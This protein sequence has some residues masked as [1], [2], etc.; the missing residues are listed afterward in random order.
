[1]QVKS[2]KAVWLVRMSEYDRWLDAQEI[3]SSAYNVKNVATA[4][5]LILR[6]FE[7]NMD[8]L[9]EAWED[10]PDGKRWVPIESVIGRSKIPAESA[11]IVRKAID[12]M[13]GRQELDSKN[14]W[15]ALEYWANSYLDGE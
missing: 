13:I 10:A 2:S 5:D 15:Q 14:M 8:Q 3:A 1:M 7:R 6:V 4:I 9:A 12:K 11:K